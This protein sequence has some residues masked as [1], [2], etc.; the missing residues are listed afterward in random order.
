M[1][2]MLRSFVDSG[3]WEVHAFLC[4]QH[5]E[6]RAGKLEVPAGIVRR[7]ARPTTDRVPDTLRSFAELCGYIQGVCPSLIMVYGD[8]LDALLGATVGLELGIPVAHLQAGDLSG[9]IDHSIRYAVSSVSRWLFC[10]TTEQYG[11]LYRLRRTTKM[12]NQ[13]IQIVGDHHIDAIAPHYAPRVPGDRWIVHLHPDTLKDAAYNREMAREVAKAVGSNAVYLP[14]CTD[15]F[16]DAIID[17]FADMGQRVVPYYPLPEFIKQLSTCRGLIGN[18]SAGVVDAPFLGVPVINIGHR[19]AGRGK[20]S[21]AFLSV[22]DVAEKAIQEC[23]A[24]LPMESVCSY[25]YGNGAAGHY[26]FDFLNR[27][28]T[29]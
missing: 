14:P 6:P 7:F 20:D 26:T 9:G 16:D 25:R 13:S 1:C 28:V 5:L 12:H 15:R 17:G 10:A 2:P 24:R 23:M 4:D 11:R 8:R 21:E 18:S 29:E 19:Q 27:E 22:E 3:C